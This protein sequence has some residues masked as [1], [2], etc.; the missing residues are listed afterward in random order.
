MQARI[1]RSSSITATGSGRPLDELRLDITVVTHGS[2]WQRFIFLRT[3][4][5]G[6]WLATLFWF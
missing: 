1:S 4:F 3:A 2:C 5:T 6:R